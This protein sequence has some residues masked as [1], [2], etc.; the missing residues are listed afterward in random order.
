M[1]FNVCALSVK[2][3]KGAFLAQPNHD[4]KQHD[5]LIC[6]H[7]IKI[8]RMLLMQ[9]LLVLACLRIFHLNSLACAI[10]LYLL[11]KLANTNAEDVLAVLFCYLQTITNHICLSLSSVFIPK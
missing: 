7:V 9:N 1:Y 4:V 6:Y 3:T 5:K 10:H 11:T 8:H 2:L